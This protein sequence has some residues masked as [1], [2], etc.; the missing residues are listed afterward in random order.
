MVPNLTGGEPLDCLV[1]AAVGG[2]LMEQWN[3][4]ANVLLL[5]RTCFVHKMIFFDGS[6]Q[7]AGTRCVQTRDVDKTSTQQCLAER[8]WL[9]FAKVSLLD[10]AR[11]RRILWAASMRRKKETLLGTSEKT[12]V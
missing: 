6:G 3:S 9:S 11:V 7:V 1:R 12:H 5:D 4:G 2:S 8:L 10:A